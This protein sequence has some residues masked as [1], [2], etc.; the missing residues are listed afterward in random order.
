[1]RRANVRWPIALAGE[2]WQNARAL[3]RWPV[4]PPAK[5]E[6]IVRCLPRD[7]SGVA[8]VPAPLRCP[9]L[10]M[11]ASRGVDSAAVRGQ[12]PHLTRRAVGNGQLPPFSL[13]VEQ[14]IAEALE[15][16]AKFLRPVQLA[17]EHLLV[18]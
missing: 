16:F 6:A 18:G 15:R 4:P 17:T 10:S 13:A 9:R 7:A 8:I 3:R 1:G 14:A 12:W 5:K 2:T 11:T